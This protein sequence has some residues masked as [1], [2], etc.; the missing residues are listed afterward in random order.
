MQELVLEVFV[1]LIFA[2][3]LEFI[4]FQPHPFLVPVDVDIPPPCPV[5]FTIVKQSNV[6]SVLQEVFQELIEIIVFH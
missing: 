3:R 5:D 1:H 6:E 4:D 2:D